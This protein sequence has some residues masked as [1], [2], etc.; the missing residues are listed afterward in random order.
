MEYKTAFQ[1][2]DRDQRSGP[3][4][5]YLSMYFSVNSTL[6]YM[7]YDLFVH[8]LRVGE[9]FDIFRQDRGDGDEQSRERRWVEVIAYLESDIFM[10]L[11]KDRLDV[12]QFQIRTL[13]KQT[14][15]IASIKWITNDLP[16]I[17]MRL[18][19]VKQQTALLN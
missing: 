1:I 13:A 9:V 18:G 12:V 10:N 14:Q 3:V 15:K 19:Q 11:R 2:H 8:L 7:L 5:I 6:D 16:Q 17:E 4:D